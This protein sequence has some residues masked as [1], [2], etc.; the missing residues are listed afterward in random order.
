[1]VFIV[2]TVIAFAALG[3]TYYK[4]R[5]AGAPSPIPLP[6]TAQRWWNKTTPGTGTSDSGST[7][8]GDGLYQPLRIRDQV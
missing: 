8:N 2:L 1:V 3:Y 4:L 7:A 5:S 6:A